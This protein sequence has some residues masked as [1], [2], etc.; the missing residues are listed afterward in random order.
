MARTVKE[1][2]DGMTSMWIQDAGIRS[3]YGLDPS[4]T[5]DGQFSS[6]S[7]ESVWFYVAAFAV[8][9]LEKLFDTHRGEMETL[10]S[11]HHAHTFNWYNSKAKAFM[12]GYPLIPFTSN[13]GVGGLTDEEISKAHI[14]TH[15]SCV[16]N[17]NANGVSFLR[18]KVAKSD[19]G[20]LRRLSDPEMSAFS[21]YMAE[22]QDAGVSVV[23]TSNEA[24]AIRMSCTVYYDPQILDANGNRLDGSAPDAVRTAIKEY[25]QNLPFNGLYKQTYHTDAIQAVE[26]VMDAYIAETLT[27]PELSENYVAVQNAGAV[28]DAGY[29]KFYSEA[30]LTVEMKA[31][32]ET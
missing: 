28:A 17:V 20:N 3:A 25:V 10:Y 15:A 5:F 23:C 16:R 11:E 30:D 27:H 24:D 2:R 22:I 29:F 6:V 8:W 31:F 26:G 19:G 14:I 7:V 4:K 12:Y 32:S 9:T 13:Y 1:I 18:L 21:D